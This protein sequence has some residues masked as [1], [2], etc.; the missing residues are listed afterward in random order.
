MAELDRPQPWASRYSQQGFEGLRAYTI[1]L[2][3]N[4]LYLSFWAVVQYGVSQLL[5]ALDLPGIDAWTLRVFQVVFA[6]VSL[7]LVVSFIIQDLG[8]IILRI[9]ANLRR[10]LSA[11]GYTRDRGRGNP[12][13][14]A[15]TQPKQ[16][17]SNPPIPLFFYVLLAVSCLALFI[18]G[19]FQWVTAYKILTR[20][21]R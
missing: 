1:S 9:F 8:G 11:A 6:I 2:V 14:D 3:F 13:P 19:V 20:F 15:G 12:G 10:E 21:E 18:A 7:A 4:A 17:E 16:A 5:T